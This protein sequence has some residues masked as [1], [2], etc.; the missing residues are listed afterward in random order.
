MTLHG[1]GVTIQ[2]GVLVCSCMSSALCARPVGSS[3]RL[4]CAFR[5]AV[6]NPHRAVVLSMHQ[7]AMLAAESRGAL[8]SKDVNY[9][10]KPHFRTSAPGIRTVIGANILLV[11]LVCTVR[12]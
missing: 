2:V 9:R 10:P 12:I 4:L 6:A 1:I 8:A 5:E 7:Q 11:W 3:H